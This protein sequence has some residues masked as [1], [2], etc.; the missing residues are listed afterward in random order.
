MKTL[1]E[2]VTIENQ[3]VL[4]PFFGSGSSLVA[5]KELNRRY[6]GFEKEE[7]YYALACERL[8]LNK[9]FASY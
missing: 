9:E 5:A 8:E 7:K 1:I 2:L 4:D 6:I 3:T